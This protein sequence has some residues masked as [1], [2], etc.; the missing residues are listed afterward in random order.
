MF[1]Y[2]L[3]LI[4]ISTAS[5]IN[6]QSDFSVGLNG[7]VNFPTG[8]FADFNTGGGG[9]F[10]FLY[11]LGNSTILSFA[12]GYDKFDLD[13]ES[14]N[15][16]AKELG[17]NVHF[18]I[19]SKFS[20]IPILLGA[21]WY[22]LQGKKHSPY[23][24]LEAG[25]YNYKFSFKGTANLIIPGGNGIPI[26]LPEI[27]ENGTKTMLK[28]SAGYLYFL[29]KN[30]FIDGSVSY[31]VLTNALAVTEP[32]DPEPDAIYGEVGTLNY[33]SLQAGINYRF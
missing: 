22:F 24:M 11:L 3:L 1:K 32:V 19:D 29:T 13:V 5:I 26:E 30:W 8:Q 7:S 10:H 25:F 6:A 16:R 12:I 4:L 9:D 28:I 15:E 27:D 18:D 20:T 2:I 23:I 14:F 17:L 31:V 21:K 33:I